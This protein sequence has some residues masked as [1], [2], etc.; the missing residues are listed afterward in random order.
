[1]KKKLL[2][3]A[4]GLV[5][6]LTTACG[7]KSS[8][9]KSSEKKEEK[10]VETKVVK[11]GVSPE[12]HQKLVELVKDDLEKEGIKL[13]IVTFTDYVQPNLALDGKELDIN[14]FQHKPYLDKFNQEKGT[15][16]SP[17]GNIHV[18]PMG[19]Y[20]NAQSEI[21]D[22]DYYALRSRYI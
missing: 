12:P 22:G 11:I 2:A 16:I 4:L 19:L 6:V 14:F 9:N 3:L 5:V 13:E 7:A 21:K 17:L 8:D 20:L 10:K 15:K 18:E 1:M